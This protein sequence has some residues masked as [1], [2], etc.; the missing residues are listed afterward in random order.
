MSDEKPFTHV[1]VSNNGNVK[2][3]AKTLWREAQKELT[4]K[5]RKNLKFICDCYEDGSTKQEEPNQTND[6][7]SGKAEKTKKLD[8]AGN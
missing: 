1:K 7:K 8:T 2:I 3:V 6:G 4:P 5:L